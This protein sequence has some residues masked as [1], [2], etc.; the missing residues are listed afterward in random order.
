LWQVTSPNGN[1][2]HTNT[3][4]QTSASY[5]TAGVYNVSLFGTTSSGCK[6]TATKTFE[7]YPKPT[8]V[9]TDS[10]LIC[11]GT[12][13]ALTVSGGV[14]G[15]YV[16]T[17]S[18]GLSCTTCDS[19]IANP[20][21]LI[22]YAVQGESSFGCLNTDTVLAR[23]Q[24]PFT[25]PEGINSTICVGK[26]VTL[27]AT[28]ASSYRWSAN[29]AN[30]GLS[31]TTGA[32]VTA[33]P[34]Q[35]TLFQVVGFD[36]K[37]CF[38]DTSVYL[39]K[40]F[41]IPQVEAGADKTINVGQTATIQATVS[42]DVTQYTWTPTNTI[43]SNSGSKIVVN[44]KTNTT[45]KL[46]VQNLGG[47]RNEDLVNVFVV[48]NGA[49]VY[50]PNTFSPNA[51]GMNDVFYPRGSGLFN[52][53]QLKIFNRWGEPVFENFNFKGNDEKAG[54]NGTYKGQPLMPDTY[55]YIIDVLCDNNTILQLNGNVTLIR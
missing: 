18:T 39:V 5:D 38:T 13:Q 54:W 24:Y 3:G 2:V 34:Q 30:A 25:M 46:V 11:K 37:N 36:D 6:D 41:P 51:D 32:S 44:P 35:T 8:I 50:I 4:T 14:S 7:V 40:V 48:C 28:G 43:V 19:P 47:C 12:G 53:K 21:S 17:P 15:N 20:D 16:W 49:N 23:V 31:S 9:A 55:V 45:Y 33:A 22:R 42:S 27:T 26:Q 29:S 10:I 1:I 52:I